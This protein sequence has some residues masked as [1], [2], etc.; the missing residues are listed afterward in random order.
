ME[1]RLTLTTQELKRLKV[2]A[3]IAGEQVTVMQAAELWGVS[4]RQSWRLLARYR[5]EGAAGLVHRNR[6]RPAPQRLPEAAREQLL[7]LAAGVCRVYND[8]H[9]TEALQEEHGWQVSRASVRRLRGAAASSA[10]LFEG[11]CSAVPSPN[12][13]T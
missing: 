13:D 9:L 4:E 2:L 5:A 7:T 12:A 1:E 10:L 8:Q 11:S 6:G 3:W